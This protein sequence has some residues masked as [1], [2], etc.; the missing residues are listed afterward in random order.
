MGASRSAQCFPCHLISCFRAHPCSSPTRV[1]PRSTH[2]EPCKSGPSAT[3]PVAWPHLCRSGEWSCFR[4]HILRA[5][6]GTLRPVCRQ[7]APLRGYPSAIT[8]CKMNRSSPRLCPIFGARVAFCALP[9]LNLFIHVA[10]NYILLCGTEY[11]HQIYSQ[12]R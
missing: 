2:P 11:L 4:S 3:G 1:P 5:L 8:L 7:V 10:I 12:L 6:P 9:L